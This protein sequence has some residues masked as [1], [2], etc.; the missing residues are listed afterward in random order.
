MRKFK[1]WMY[2]FLNANHSFNLISKEYGVQNQLPIRFEAQ[3]DIRSYK[4][5]PAHTNFDTLVS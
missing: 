3:Q 2:L 5:Q 4:F 1:Q